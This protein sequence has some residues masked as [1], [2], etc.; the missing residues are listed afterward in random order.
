MVSRNATRS[1]ENPVARFPG[2]P[3][4]RY[5]ENLVSRYQ[6][7]T[8]E[9]PQGRAASRFP[10]RRRSLSRWLPRSSAMEPCAPLDVAQSRTGSAAQTTC[11]VLLLLLTVHLLP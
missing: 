6:G 1:P 2:S 4:H 9:I 3:V 10:E 8:A 11:T 5:P 7:R